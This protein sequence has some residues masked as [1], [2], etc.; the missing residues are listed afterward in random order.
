MLTKRQLLILNSIIELFTIDGQP[1]GSKKLVD[2]EIIGASSA[3]I[4]NEMNVLEELGFIEK[5]HSSSGR[6][7]SVKGYRFYVDNL[8]EPKIIN[9]AKRTKIKTIMNTHVYQMSDIFNQSAELLSDLTSYTSIVLGP[10]SKLKKLTGFRIVQLNKKQ[11]LIVMQ[12]D[13][14]DVQNMIFRIPNGLDINHIRK[15]ADFMNNNLVGESLPTVYYALK[16]D[17]PEM[18]EEFLELNWDVA[19]TLEKTL[20]YYDNEQLFISGKTNL[21][22]FTDN[23][24]VRQIKDLYNLLDNV[25][26]LSSLLN[27]HYNIGNN[28]DIR[29][30]EE[31]EHQLL[32]SFSLITVPYHDNQF[33]NGVI[34]VL[35]PKNMTYDATLGVIQE[36]RT[37]LLD[38]LEDFY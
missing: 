7:P 9:D 37:E 25:G 24:Q 33:G 18:F 13:N 12:L 38:R 14:Y 30:G 31:F 20:S 11:M 36:L 15:V 35:G 4:R 22:D 3:T 8:M 5:V 28:F 6:I 27:N 34:A 19:K 10:Q 16:N 26:M 2:L 17:I 29:I 23:M 32:E 1:V 21:L